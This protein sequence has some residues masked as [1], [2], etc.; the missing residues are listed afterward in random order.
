[1]A[2]QELDQQQSDDQTEALAVEQ[3]RRQTAEQEVARLTGEVEQLRSVMETYAEQIQTLQGGGDDDELAALRSELML[4]RERADA[5]VADLQQALSEAR[6]ALQE[7]ALSDSVD[8]SEND[9]IKSD[10][11]ALQQ[12]ISERDLELERFK[13]DA[14]L[15][16]E[17]L[18]ARDYKIDSLKIALENAQVEAEE[19][20]FSRDETTEAKKLVDE[21][22]YKLQ[23]D[24]Q[25]ERSQQDLADSRLAKAGSGRAL[26][27]GTLTGGG[28]LIKGVLVG[29]IIAFVAAEGLSIG[30]GRGEL[31]SNFIKGGAGE[32][33]FSTGKK[34]AV[35]TQASI[36]AI[37]LDSGQRIDERTAVSAISER[38]GGQ[39]NGVA[40]TGRS[41]VKEQ[42]APSKLPTPA[43]E[44][45]AIAKPPKR[46]ARKEPETGVVLRDRLSDESFG[47]EMLYVRGATFTMG[48]DR[49]QIAASERPAHRVTLRSF[50]IGRYE[51][52]FE[53]YQ[54][55]AEVTG[56]LL[57][58]DQGWGRGKRPVIN[59]SWSDAKAYTDWLSEQTG[60]RYRLPTEAEWEYAAGGGSESAY[61]WGYEMVTGRAN[62]FNCGTTWDGVST[63]PVGS[64]EP[65]GFGLHNTAGNVIEW[66]EDC[67]HPDYRGAPTD[68]SAWSEA[69][70][71]QFSTRGGGFNKP[72]DSLR[73][74]KR[75]SHDQNAKLPVLGFRVVREVR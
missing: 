62:C 72:D 20:I 56:R 75:S 58:N 7:Q 14:M 4:V 55:F 64:F 70:C 51:V 63:A 49:S 25:K 41:E 46:T 1:Q 61:W 5:D 35:D 50:A 3:Q 17:K 8:A 31:I 44:K 11:E 23:Q 24:L 36:P 30:A 15:F 39:F 47:P 57:P 65:N 74:T 52:T 12:S 37:A 6:A 22:L 60:Q 69:D 18:T 67:Y 34:R 21:A 66:T 33:L 53:E 40:Q 59:V 54:R 71:A 32:Q 13:H 68:G 38:T 19:A 42:V 16:Q 45:Q 48:S 26:D 27:I 28:S 29:A 9:A 73:I 10:L 43:P 2:R